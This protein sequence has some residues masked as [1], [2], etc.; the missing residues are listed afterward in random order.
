[1]KKYAVLYGLYVEKFDGKKKD[2]TFFE[3][4]EKFL[5]EDSDNDGSK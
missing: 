4:V 2:Q 1:M 3:Y 5:R